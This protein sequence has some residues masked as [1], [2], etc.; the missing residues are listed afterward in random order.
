[1]NKWRGGST[2]GKGDEMG[3]GWGR[4]SL[5]KMMGWICLWENRPE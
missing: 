4:V 3:K 1:V 5:S 2:E